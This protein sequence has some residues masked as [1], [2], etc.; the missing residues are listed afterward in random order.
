M[1]NKNLKKYSDDLLTL[2]VQIKKNNDAK[3]FM[4]CKF[5]I[6]DGKYLV[7]GSM[8]FGEKSLKNYEQLTVSQD[9]GKIK[10]F[11]QRFMQ[12]WSNVNRFSDYVNEEEETERI[13]ILDILESNSE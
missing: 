6:I 4:H 3:N 1:T 2:G 12:M 13:E 5:M 11:E 9:E 8:N 10:K 7:E